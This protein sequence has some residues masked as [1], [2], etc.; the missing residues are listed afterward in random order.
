VPQLYQMR[1]HGEQQEVKGDLPK[2]Y[3]VKPDGNDSNDGLS[4]ETAWQSLIYAIRQLEPGDTLYLLNGTWTNPGRVWFDYRTLSGIPT[5]PI[6]MK[7]YNGTPTLDGAGEKATIEIEKDW[8]VLEG[9][10][11]INGTKEGGIW[12]KGSYVTVENCISGGHNWGGI[13]AGG[14]YNIV[15]NCTAYNSDMFGISLSGHDNIAE[16][17][18]V[19][20]YPDIEPKCDYAFSSSPGWGSE[21]FYHLTYR[22]CKAIGRPDAGFGHGFAFTQGKYIDDIVVHHS[23]ADNCTVEYAWAG[24]E[25]RGDPHDILFHNCSVFHT[26][27]ENCY[28]GYVHS[29]VANILKNITYKNVVVTGVGAGFYFSSNPTN[30]TVK[31][32][33]AY[34]CNWGFGVFTN[35]TTVEN[36]VAANNTG[37]GASVGANVSVKN[38]IFANNTRGIRS[39][40]PSGISY[41]N[42]WGNG[43]NYF[44]THP[45]I[46]DGE[47]AKIITGGMSEDPLFADPDS[48]DFHLKSQY[49]RWNGSAWVTDNETSPCIDAGDP[50]EK[51]PDGTRVNMGAYGGTWEASKSPSAATGTLTGIVTDKDTGAPIEGA[52]IEANSHQTTTNSTGDY[53]Q[54]YF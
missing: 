32:S 51:D 3:Y 19:Y 53:M 52:L 44:D 41:C 21:S 15:R 46:K 23:I 54:Y 37:I 38:S 20:Q 43:D 7:A 28:G 33:I 13:S 47:L 25:C 49:G 9:I 48:G 42:F 50:S 5:H 12:I 4:I 17:C 34:N 30:I 35:N 11:V 1:G 2:T 27:K 24:L 39:E 8:I 29:T 10:K 22:N 40:N 14:S 16:D 26:K 36:C 45:Y 6:V 31:N 18:T